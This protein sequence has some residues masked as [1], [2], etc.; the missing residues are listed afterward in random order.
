[1]NYAHTRAPD[2]EL[3]DSRMDPHTGTGEF[4]L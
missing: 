3:Y 1:S 2:L 4:G